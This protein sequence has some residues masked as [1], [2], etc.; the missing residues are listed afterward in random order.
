[1]PMKKKLKYSF[2][3]LYS[4]DKRD[5]KFKMEGIPTKRVV[6]L[7]EHD[8][9]NGNQ[10]STPYCVGF[11]AS[12]WLAAMP[13]QQWLDPNGLYHYANAT[14][15][16]APKAHNG[17]SIRSVM[18]V[19]EKLGLIAEYQWTNSVDI[20]VTNV[21]EKS[22]VVVGTEWLS[23]MTKPKPTGFLDCSGSRVGG[24]AYLIIGVNTKEQYF[25]IKNSWGVDWGEEGTALIH[26][27]DMQKLIAVRNF[28]EVCLAVEKT[29]T[30]IF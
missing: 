15:E 1:M 3:R 16:W 24:H 4:P 17:T 5:N 23:N 10:K 22:P 19:L 13:V 28:G 9:W 30:P 29:P 8:F 26:F 2:G 12:H 20:L 6:R 27:D 18:K 21:L 11:A 14:D 7:W 25:T